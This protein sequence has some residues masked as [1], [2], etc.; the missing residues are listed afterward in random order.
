MLF[1]NG[2]KITTYGDGAERLN[3]SSSHRNLYRIVAERDIH[4]GLHDAVDDSN[5]VV[6]LSVIY[7]HAADDLAI[8]SD[9]IWR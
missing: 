8:S 3:Q 1:I 6:L 5:D 2:W 7:I 9:V 4:E